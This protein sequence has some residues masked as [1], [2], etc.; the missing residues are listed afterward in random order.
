M[1]YYSQI[2][3]LRRLAEM[4]QSGCEKAVGEHQEAEPGDE[5]KAAGRPKGKQGA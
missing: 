2:G 3:D 1:Y 4:V 5:A